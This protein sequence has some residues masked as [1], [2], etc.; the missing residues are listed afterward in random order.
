LSKTRRE[1]QRGITGGD[2]AGSDLR[3]RA[4]SVADD[5]QAALGELI[6]PI[7]QNRVTVGHEPHPTGRC[8]ESPEKP[9]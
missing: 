7:D 9:D 4:A 6:A 5:D 2:L 3:R 1:L 8:S